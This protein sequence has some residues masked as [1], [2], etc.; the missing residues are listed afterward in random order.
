MLEY[1]QQ[2]RNFKEM[3]GTKFLNPEKLL[4]T[5]VTPGMT[6]ADFGSGN[7][8]YSVAAAF[9]VGKKGQV[10]AI[11]VMDDALS[12]TATLAKLSG[13]QNVSTKQC[14]LEKF[15]SCDLPETSCDL[16][17]ISSLMHQVENKDNVIREA[18]RVLKTGGRLLIVEWKPD[19]R[20]GPPPSE[21]L[22][23]DQLRG[24]LEK[25]GFRPSGEQEAGS[26]H[27]ALL[28]QK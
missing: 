20:F 13:L 25:Y 23:R 17:I 22:D 14:D 1:N 9:L 12:Q 28:Y 21:R 10:Y 8:Y 4:T 6:V 26:F 2:N 15:G 24:L 5:T 19:S 7:G 3:N 27:Y 11:D 18:Y 16:V